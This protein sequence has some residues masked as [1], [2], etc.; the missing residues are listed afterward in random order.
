MYVYKTSS[1]QMYVH[2]YDNKGEQHRR[3]LGY[4]VNGTYEGSTIFTNKDKTKYW[5]FQLGRYNQPYKVV[6]PNWVV[7]IG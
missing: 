1:G 4:P 6:L 3:Y 5:F 7:T 2:I